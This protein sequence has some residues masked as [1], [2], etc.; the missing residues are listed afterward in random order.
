MVDG[1][2]TGDED[3]RI[4]NTSRGPYNDKQR[5]MTTLKQQQQQQQPS[6]DMLTETSR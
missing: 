5:V 6:V 4:D 3:W 1:G 2:L